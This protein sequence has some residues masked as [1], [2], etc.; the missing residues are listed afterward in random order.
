[1]LTTFADG[2]HMILFKLNSRASAIS[3]LMIVGAKNLL[4]LLLSQRG[5]NAL[6]HSTTALSPRPFSR[7]VIVGT[8]NPLP[9]GLAGNNTVSATL[10]CIF[11]IGSSGDQF[12]A[13]GIV[14]SPL[15]NAL[16][17][18]LFFFR[19]QA[20]IVA[21]IPRQAILNFLGHNSCG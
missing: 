18:L 5:R 4:P 6:Q 15:S 8:D 10:I 19:R 1:M 20:S 13:L 2:K 14:C 21:L 17:A 9:S 3:A 12:G 11:G 16:S 7:S